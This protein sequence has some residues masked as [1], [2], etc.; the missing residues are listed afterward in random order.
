MSL[1]FVPKRGKTEAEIYFLEGDSAIDPLSESGGGPIDVGAV[2]LQ[3]T[4]WNLSRPRLRR[5]IF[6]DEPFIH[7]K[8]VEPNERA[9]DVIKSISNELGIQVLMVSDERVSRSS[10]LERSDKVFETKK[11]KSISHTK[12]IT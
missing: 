6:L 5:A 9:L 8:G 1:N 10:I 2:A 7:L 3:F 4:L 12:E 11:R